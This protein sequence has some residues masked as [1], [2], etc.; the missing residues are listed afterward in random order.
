MKT[1]ASMFTGGGLFDIGAIQAGYTS[2]WGIEYDDK[3][4]AVA[5]SNN[6]PVITADVIE[7]DFSN[8][9]RPNHLHASPPCPNFSVAKK[10]AK[11]TERDIAMAKSVCRAITTLRPDTFTLE[12]VPAYVHGKSFE[13]I[14]NTL[15]NAGYFV[16]YRNLNSADFGV[17]QTR[18]RLWVRAGRKLMSDYPAPIEWVGWYAAIE[19]L[20]PTLPDA[21]FAPWQVARLPKEYKDFLIGQGQRSLPI[22]KDAPSNTITSNSNQTGVKAFIFSGAGNTSFKEAADGKGVRYS[23]KPSHTVSSDGGVRTPKAFVPDRDDDMPFGRVV[24]MTVQ[25]LGRFQT[26]PDSYKGLTVKINGNGVPCK[27][28]KAVIQTLY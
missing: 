3:I 17:P 10:G 15:H 6:L 23:D 25:A 20:I 21:Q 11:E 28:A 13:T 22:D 5:R 19:D 12:N 9:E 16:N 27:Q 2:I 18:R 14:I 4:A 26:V 1:T 8:Y 24:K 7:V